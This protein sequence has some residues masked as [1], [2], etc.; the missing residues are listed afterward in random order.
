MWF[1]WKNTEV[2]LS[3][4]FNKNYGLLTKDSK[5]IDSDWFNWSLINLMRKK[6]N[7]LVM[8]FIWDLNELENISNNEKFFGKMITWNEEETSIEKYVK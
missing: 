5:S 3:L 8:V 6:K 4:D 1:F 7:V 2:S